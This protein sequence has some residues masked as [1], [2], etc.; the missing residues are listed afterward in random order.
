MLKITSGAD[1]VIFSI[2]LDVK[3]KDLYRIRTIK[4]F[5]NDA[6]Y[7]NFE[8]YNITDSGF[9]DIVTVPGG[10]E[11]VE[12]D[13][14]IM[15]V[16]K[17]IKAMKDEDKI[18]IKVNGVF[19]GK[20]ESFFVEDNSELEKNIVGIK[21]GDIIR[22]SLNADNEI[23]I[24]EKTLLLSTTP[25]TKGPTV[26]NSYTNQVCV[27]YGTLSDYD[28]VRGAVAITDSI[29]QTKLFYK[30]ISTRI[31]V[32]DTVNKRVYAGTVDDILNGIAETN[33]NLEVVVRVRYSDTK[34]IVIIKK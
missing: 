19:K 13:A 12:G 32:Y 30:L 20:D 26:S 5:L 2:P 14:D 9:V 16:N 8:A 18:G 23:C 24:L 11:T 29:T 28:K 34:D 10:G 15:V 27:T 33:R 17:L 4:D 6:F 25:Y 21:Q 22:F 3:N 1:A 7:N 31:S